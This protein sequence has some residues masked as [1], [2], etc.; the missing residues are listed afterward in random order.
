MSKA[1]L[2][3]VGNDGI[4][5]VNF[6][7]PNLIHCPAEDF[8]APNQA[9]N[10]NF[11]ISHFCPSSNVANNASMGAATRRYTL[12]G[13]VR[14]PENKVWLMDSKPNALYVNTGVMAVIDPY[15][16]ISHRGNGDLYMRHSRLANHLYFDGHTE[17]K[18]LVEINSSNTPYSNYEQ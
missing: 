3:N 18:S 15:N 8:R 7:S 10:N 17:S 14:Y 1:G 5:G 9:M 11:T 12:I 6:T 2:I 16:P 4:A 13:R